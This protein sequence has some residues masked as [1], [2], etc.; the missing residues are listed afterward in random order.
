[1]VEAALE[2]ETPS[3]ERQDLRGYWMKRRTWP[4]DRAP[5]AGEEQRARHG[6]PLCTS[7][8]QRPG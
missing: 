7:E 4:G 2:T 5:A 3:L 8:E 6:L 1:M